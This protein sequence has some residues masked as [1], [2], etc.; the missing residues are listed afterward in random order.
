VVADFS[1]DDSA[2]LPYQEYVRDPRN[3]Y[4]SV[5]VPLDDG[6]EISLRS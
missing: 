4:V 6:V 5:T 1:K 3:G 2:L